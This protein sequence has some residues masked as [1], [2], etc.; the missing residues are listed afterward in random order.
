MNKYFLILTAVMAGLL[1]VCTVERNNPLDEHGENFD[2]PTVKIYTLETSV[3]ANDTTHFDSVKVSLI[4]N[5][6][7]SRF[8]TNLDSNS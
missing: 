3:K 8:Q 1:I 7:E 6:K 4:G 2:Q 5:K